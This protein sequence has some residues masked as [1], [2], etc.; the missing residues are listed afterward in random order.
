MERAIPKTQNILVDTNVFLEFL[1]EQDRYQESLSLMRA[2]EQGT[3][4]AH[5]TTFAL[6]S[7]EVIL[8]GAG[9][10]K[11]LGRFLLWV[12]RAKGLTVYPTSPEEEREV[13]AITQRLQLDFDD[14]LQYYVC[15]HLNLTLVS[16]DKD[17]DRTGIE[18]KE[19][20][21]LL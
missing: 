20:S 16:F 1:L 9:R 3:R 10:Q 2:V 21:E 14:A 13:V 12:T 4:N 8:D 7:I 15:S 17:F 18:R 5:I 19:P 11:K 6:H